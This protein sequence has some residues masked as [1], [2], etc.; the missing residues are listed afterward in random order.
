MAVGPLNG[1]SY[2]ERVHMCVWFDFL[3]RAP[4]FVKKPSFP[5][6]I[7]PGQEKKNITANHGC[8]GLERR[9]SLPLKTRS[10]FHTGGAT[11]APRRTSRINP[12]SPAEDP[13]VFSTKIENSSH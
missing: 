9:T 12:E 4:G 2:Y 11:T 1:F 6:S 3:K 5:L 7:L 13:K 10:T 8:E